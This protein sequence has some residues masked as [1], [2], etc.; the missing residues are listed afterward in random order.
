MWHS[1]DSGQE[2][3][4]CR[5]SPSDMTSRITLPP[6]LAVGSF[7]VAVAGPGLGLD[8]HTVDVVRLVLRRQIT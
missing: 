5:C 1:C 4:F 7:T 2:Q 3:Y 6:Q 8:I